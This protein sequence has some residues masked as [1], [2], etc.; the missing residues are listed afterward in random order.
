[1]SFGSPT[2]RRI[3]QPVREELSVPDGPD[4]GRERGVVIDPD[5]DREIIQAPG[6]GGG[7]ATRGGLGSDRVDGPGLGLCH[8]G[9]GTAVPI[10]TGAGAP[11]VAGV[12]SL[13]R[14]RTGQ[15]RSQRGS[16]SPLVRVR[17]RVPT[18]G[19]RWRG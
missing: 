11:P 3:A 19:S 8:P 7:G 10:R 5:H 17:R 12:V 9:H 14:T 18:R 2:P 6:G 16:T 13:A 4:Q 1:M 15:L